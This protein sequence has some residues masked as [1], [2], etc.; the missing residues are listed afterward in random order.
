M[1]FSIDEIGVHLLRKLITQVTLYRVRDES[2]IKI[3]IF[4]D[5]ILTDILLI[6]LP[7]KVINILYYFKEL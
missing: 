7:K 1:I 6:D 3:K 5:E 4:I 2:L